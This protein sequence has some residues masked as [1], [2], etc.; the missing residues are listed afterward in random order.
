MY[1]V[2]KNKKPYGRP[3]GLTTCNVHVCP[4]GGATSPRIGDTDLVNLKQQADAV[5]TVSV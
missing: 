3:A 1:L 5:S 4:Q 2:I